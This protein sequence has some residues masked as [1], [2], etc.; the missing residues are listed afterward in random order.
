MRNISK[1][2]LLGKIAGVF[3]LRLSYSA[4]T[5]VT[6]VVLARVLGASGFG[7]YTYVVVWA[8]F[9]SLPATMG[10]DNFIVR[11]V[12]IYQGQG[13]WSLMRGLLAWANRTVLFTSVGLSLIAILIAWILNQGFA[14]EAFIVFCV[15]MSLM[16]AI[17][18]RNIRRAAMKG[19]HQVSKGLLPEL[20]IDPL[21]LLILT[22]VAYVLLRQNITVLWVVSFY[23][24]GSCVTLVIVNKFLQ[25]SMPREALIAPPTYQGKLWF[26][27]TLPFLL[28]ESLP[29]LNSRI[30]VLMLGG[31]NGFDSVGLYVP[32]S[33]SAQL[34]VFILIAVGNTLAPTIASAY[35]DNKLFDLQK[36]ITKSVRLI[37]GIAFV[38]SIAL[39]VGSYWYL[40]L[41]GAEYLQGKNALYLFCIGSFLST[42]MGLSFVILNMT[43]HERLTAIVGWLSVGLNIIF[44]A[45]CIPKWGIEGAAFA[46]SLSNCLRTLVGVIVVRKKLG[47]DATGFGLMPKVP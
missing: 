47:I 5:F 21:I 25:Q 34:I 15:A 44:N 39:S 41:F 20:L 43:G 22:G 29:I 17:S 37:I 23:G 38:F 7:T 19:L 40:A 24:V 11:E 12:A 33:R 32:I 13:S 9:L 42:S 35:A 3:G 4:L 31:I 30:D 10:L 8:Y 2:K 36:T 18:L 28:V 6:S 27:S 16:P 1:N 14:S 45:I 26:W 46:T